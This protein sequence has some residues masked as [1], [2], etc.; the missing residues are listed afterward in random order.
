MLFYH[1]KTGQQKMSWRVKIGLIAGIIAGLSF[2]AI[3]TFTF[4]LI[5]LVSYLALLVL[6]LIRKPPTSFPHNAHKG[7]RHYRAPSRNDDIIDI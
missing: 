7:A 3:F 1:I 4:I 2:L 6:N 5:I